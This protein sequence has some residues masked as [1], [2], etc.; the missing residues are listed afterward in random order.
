MAF[1]LARLSIRIPAAL[2]G[3]ALATGALIGILSY[4]SSSNELLKASEVKLEALAEARKAELAQYLGSIVEDLSVI[5]R[6]P[7]VSQALLAY[8]DAWKQLGDNPQATLQKAYIQDNPNP[9]GEKDALMSAGTSAYDTV[10]STYHPWLRDFLKTR[11]YYDIFLFNQSGDLIYTV[12]KELDYATNLNTGTWRDSDLGNAFRA[13][14][15]SPAG[16]AAFFDFKGYGPSN[17]AQASFIATPVFRDGERIGVLAFQ[18]PVD[19]LNSIMGQADGLGVSGE[20]ILIGADGRFRADSAKSPEVN[21]IQVTELSG[22]VIAAGIAG[23]TTTGELTGYR[24]ATFVAAV[25]PLEFQGTN[26]TIVAV[27]DYDEV[28]APA[29]QLRNQILIIFAGAAVVVALVGL[30]IAR[31]IV[32]PIQ[33]L[34]RDASELAGGNVDVDFTATSRKDEIGDIA[35]A[36]AG[37]RDTVAEQARLAAAEARE[38]EERLA[39]QKRIE[40]L[41]DQFR[42]QSEEMLGSVASNMQQMQ[43][44]AQNLIRIS[45]SAAETAGSAADATTTASQ[46]VQVVASAAEELSA[47]ISEIGGRVNETTLVIRDATQQAIESNEKMNNLATAAQRIGEVVDLIRA[48]AEQTN[49]LALNATIEAAR[50][51]EAGRGFAVVAAEVK[52]LANQTSKA[53]EEISGQVSE[54]Q[55]WTG[56]AVRAISGIAEIMDKANQYTSSIAAAVQ[57]QDAATREISRSA[58]DTSSSTVA[59]ARNM[60]EVTSSVAETRTCANEVDTASSSVAGRVDQLGHLVSSFLRNVAAA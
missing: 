7:M 3:C 15:K 1:S 39:R 38:Q 52:E 2:V 55:S 47:S 13:A 42:F 40:D 49:L 9:A 58:S 28:T 51:G 59:A 32:R 19:R 26:W 50:A 46:N 14:A 8:D 35:Q 12:F 16:T 22:D 21:D 44:T 45:T 6:S 56:D 60:N 18:M 41:L 10:H 43:T 57:E 31:G 34:V 24:D 23:K 27:Q 33:G 4:Q 29:R 5:S 11:G 30:F 36:I 17:G 20:T 54:I 37:F 48:I 25:T 53:T